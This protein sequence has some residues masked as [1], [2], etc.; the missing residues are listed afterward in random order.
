MDGAASAACETRGRSSM[1]KNDV[2]VM[3]GLILAMLLLGFVIAIFA[4]LIVELSN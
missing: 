1:F 3:I 2:I 4:P